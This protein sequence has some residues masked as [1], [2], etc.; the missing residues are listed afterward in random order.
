MLYE[1]ITQA[2]LDLQPVGV[3]LFGVRQQL[4]QNF[5]GL[6]ILLLFTQA[7]GFLQRLGDGIFQL[8]ITTYSIHYT[9]LYDQLQGLAIA[10]FLQK[11]FDNAHLE[12]VV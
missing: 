10:L 9:K 3:I 4:L 8:V 5:T 1:V 7:D 6:V 12:L 2:Q 11:P